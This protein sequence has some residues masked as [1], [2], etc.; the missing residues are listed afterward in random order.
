[1]EKFKIFDTLSQ[2]FIFTESQNNKRKFHKEIDKDKEYILNYY[3]NTPI[4][5][6]KID[7]M[8]MHSRGYFYFNSLIKNKFN[9][10]NFFIDKIF[11]SISGVKNK[12]KNSSIIGLRKYNLPKLQLIK[13]RK[14][15]MDLKLR[16]KE[17]EENFEKN[18]SMEYNKYPFLSSYKNY[19]E[20]NTT[21]NKR[22]LSNSKSV[23]FSGVIKDLEINTSQNQKNDLSHSFSTNLL[24]SNKNSEIN[25]FNE[26]ERMNNFKNILDKCQK[27][28]KSGGKIGGKVEKY[29]K[30]LNKSLSKEKKIRNNKTTYILQD[31]KIVEDKVSPKQ[32]YK[33]LEIEKFQEIKKRINAKISDNMVYFNRKEYSELVNDKRK[34]DEYNLY[35]EEVNKEYE[36]LVQN[37]IKE[38]TKFK[39]IK[40]LLEDSYK[41]KNYLANKIKNYYRKRFI[42]KSKAYNEKNNLEIITNEDGE[43]GTNLGTL[44]PKLLSK[45]KE[46][47][48]KNKKSFF[49]FD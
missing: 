24:L 22:L 12:T 18:H 17:D 5:K 25:S 10:K 21:N 19:L 14:R 47:S 3:R 34:L 23:I 46:N 8:E 1:M 26:K 40:N 20:S 38:K 30:K 6:D 45:K 29:K 13:E 32:K 28:I 42:Q 39:K 15:R 36:N 4:Y 43:R 7:N 41:K 44:L 48:V 27:E 2:R 33:L 35:Y 11:K 49:Y 9:K 37:R 16:S 31:K